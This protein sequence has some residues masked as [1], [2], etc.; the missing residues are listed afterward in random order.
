[1]ERWSLAIDRDYAAWDRER[2]VLDTADGSVEHN[3]KIL[4]SALAAKISDRE[5]TT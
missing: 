2:I 5:P 3:V 1:M 4:R